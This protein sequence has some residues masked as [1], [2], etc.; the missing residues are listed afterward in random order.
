MTPTDESQCDLIVAVGDSADRLLAAEYGLQRR[1]AAQQAPRRFDAALWD[2]FAGLGLLGIG[3]P[4]E[5]Q[6]F[7]GTLGDLAH[8]TSVLGRHLVLSPFSATVATAAWTIARCAPSDTAAVLLSRIASGAEIVAF[9]HSER[10]GILA[11][12]GLRTR[13]STAGHKLRVSG[14]KSLVAHAQAA[15][16]LL[17][18]ARVEGQE[19]A[20]LCLVRTNAAG[21]SLDPG[22]LHDGTSFADVTFDNTPVEAALSAG[23]EGRDPLEMAMEAAL[24]V[25]LAE[26]VS[27]MD[28]LVAR[29][30]DYLRTRKQ[31]GRTIGSFQA[32]QHRL[33]EMAVALEQAR[34]AALLATEEASLQV[35]RD[36]RG[37]AMGKV[38]VGLNS[39][40]VAQGAI[41]LH[42]GI[43]MTEELD[44]GFFLRRLM[45]LEQTLGSPSSHLAQ[46][47]A[48]L[49]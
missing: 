37:L 48:R 23:P 22:V 30:A 1:K 41:Q 18:S 25:N 9:A 10:G 12:K 29:T 38:L 2:S 45:V 13:I 31:F 32:L 7:G 3:I 6:G 11:A 16:T 27:C 35:E 44:V 39:R 19:L 17:V 24:V 20:Q 46:L 21:V 36:R 42:G 33:A 5:H 47:A 15:D 14:S 43:G 34:S 8:I 26:A 40:L 28:M 4:E 49:P